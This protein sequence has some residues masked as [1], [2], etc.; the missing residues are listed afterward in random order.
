MLKGRIQEG[1][2]TNYLVQIIPG[3]VLGIF[4]GRLLSEIVRP[5]PPGAIVI[6]LAS[7][8]F[9]TMIVGRLPFSQTWPCL[10]LLLYII[11]PEADPKTAVF[12]ILFF[13]FVGVVNYLLVSDRSPRN[14]QTLSLVAGF[15]LAAIFLALYLFTISPDILPADNG[16]FQLVATELGIAHPPGFSLYTMLA[17]LMT[18]LS[19]GASPA[20]MV[21]LFSVIISVFTLLVVYHAVFTLTKSI[22]AGM[23][24]AL[25]LGIATTFWAQATVANIRSL[26]ALYTAILLLLAIKIWQK[27]RPIISDSS[28]KKKASEPDARQLVRYLLL[29]VLTLVLGITHHPSL[30]FLAVVLVPFVI[31]VFPRELIT[32]RVLY[33]VV[34]TGLLGLIPLL[35]FPIRAYAGALGT[36]EDLLTLSGFINHVL[37]LGFRGDLFFLEDPAVFWNRLRMMGNVATF[38]IPPVLLAMTAIGVL[39]ALWRDRWLGLILAISIILYTVVAASYRA[40][41]TVEYMMP[42]YV[43][44]AIAMGYL[45]GQLMDTQKA[46]PNRFK[47]PSLLTAISAVAIGLILV[48]SIQVV[49]EKYPSY[50]F[51]HN[52]ATTRNYTQPL[53]EQ[54]PAD[55]IILADWH[56]ATPLWYLQR[57]EGLRPDVEVEFVFP[58]GE[59]YAETWARRIEEEF[60]KGRPVIATH[61]NEPAYAN[62]P[63]PEPLNDAFLFSQEVRTAL[64]P[65]FLPLNIKLRQEIDVLGY[66]LDE[67]SVAPGSEIV[68]T[69]AWQKASDIDEQSNLF[70]HLVN[71]EGKLFGQDDV[72]AVTRSEGINLTQLRLT[73]LLT[74][75]PGEYELHIGSYAPNSFTEISDPANA[76]LSSLQVER[77][78]APVFT[79][80]EVHRPTA[81]SDDNTVLIGYDWD[82]TIPGNKRL[83]LHWKNDA[84]FWVEAKDLTDES[85]PMSDWIGPWGQEIANSALSTVNDSYFVPHGQGIIWLGPSTQN[86]QS[87]EPGKPLEIDGDFVSSGPVASDLTVSMR[88]VGY[89][90]DD[91][92]WAWWDLVDGTPAMGAIPTLKWI[93][94]S[95]VRDP[96]WPTVSDDAYEGQVIEPLL[97]LYDAFTGRPLPILD[98]RL[99]SQAPWIPLGKNAVTD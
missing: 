31:I 1:N 65:E 62:L 19:F 3:I 76:V 69:L 74:T 10:L 14:H 20:F 42:T 77:L 4:L 33:L 9:A 22:I 86:H 98:E 26:T 11:H 67:K 89:E 97:R 17:H 72:P 8:I 47:Y 92:H 45:V 21:N 56:W 85:L 48:T 16:E 53:L 50:A 23:A 13:G 94:S 79:D 35:Y 44:G 37:A 80:N 84:G 60:E 51:L 41:Q 99:S 6:T 90:E 75:P 49:F 78:S 61:F 63:P 38:Q 58:T 68:L 95:R 91:F 2:L 83:Y 25:T 55:G 64:P 28:S 18:R 71:D 93:D 7:I 57:V 15:I 24:G 5:S 82:N 54:A 12:A 29:F 88:L 39:L 70:A 96:R 73:P 52:D 27:T 87:L 46:L 32:R 43:L 81:D 66:E 30:I 34:F 40:P 59:P 36:P